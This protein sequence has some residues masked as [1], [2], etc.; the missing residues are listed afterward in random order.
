MPGLAGGGASN[1][2]ASSNRM[3]ARVPDAWSSATTVS[4]IEGAVASAASATATSLLCVIRPRA[5]Q[6]LLT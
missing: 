3:P 4:A 1:R 6:L 2:I 5:R